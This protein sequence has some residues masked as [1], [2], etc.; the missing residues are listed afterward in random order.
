M[1]GHEYIR[2]GSTRQTDPIRQRDKHI[3]F[4]RHER[5]KRWILIDHGF[6]LQRELQGDRFFLNT[7]ADGA[8]I[9]T[10]MARVM[11]IRRMSSDFAGTGF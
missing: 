4:A 8:R 2:I 10:A 6:Q 7:G 9:N 5:V 3:R 11:A 1:N